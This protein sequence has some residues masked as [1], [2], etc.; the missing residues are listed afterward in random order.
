MRKKKT[1]KKIISRKRRNSRKRSKN[2]YSMKGGG[3]TAG[4]EGNVIQGLQ[5][6]V[7]DLEE[8]NITLI[9]E[10]QGWNDEMDR[11]KQLHQ[12]QIQELKELRPENEEKRQYIEEL[13]HR[14]KELDDQRAVLLEDN[15]LTA[16]DEQQSVGD[17]SGEAIGTAPVADA[18]RAVNNT[19]PEELAVL[20]SRFSAL[21]AANNELTGEVRDL[22]DARASEQTA[23]LEAEQ[24]ARLK[25]E[26]AA[27]ADSETAR[28]EA[29][30]AKLVKTLTAEQAQMPIRMQRMQE[31]MERMRVELDLA[32]Q[33]ERDAELLTGSS[34]S[35][36]SL[37]DEIG[38]IERPGS[39]VTSS[40]DDNVKDQQI[41]NLEAKVE[42]KDQQ[43]ANL[44]AEVTYQKSKLDLPCTQLA[45]FKETHHYRTK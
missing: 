21:Q 24:T 39:P 27:K 9:T 15:P 36:P 23:R 12:R 19:A 13:E 2:K 5:E 42:A 4:D 43:I 38:E 8:E 14:V 45:I 32:N 17:D 33:R 44:E 1:Y 3:T 37:F 22:S 11:V 26:Q 30:K 6:R 16:T 40:A 20:K 34:E 31:E 10:K 41:A 29:E 35:G 7:D 18:P 25:T 28:V